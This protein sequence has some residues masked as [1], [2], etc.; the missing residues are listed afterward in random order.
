MQCAKCKH[1]PIRTK[2][3]RQRGPVTAQGTPQKNLLGSLEAVRRRRPPVHSMPAFLSW[4]IP[5]H[6]TLCL[7]LS[8]HGKKTMPSNLLD[9]SL[10]KCSQELNEGSFHKSSEDLWTQSRRGCWKANYYT[11]NTLGSYVQVLKYL[12]VFCG[13][14]PL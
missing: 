9:N 13:Y 3:V 2:T 4:I 10:T 14:F 12:I 6:C 1:L 7:W 5:E 8:M 11:D